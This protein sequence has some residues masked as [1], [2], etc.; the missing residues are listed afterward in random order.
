MRK[1]VRFCANWYILEWAARDGPGAA[2]RGGSAAKPPA[3]AV[4]TLGPPCP[5]VSVGSGPGERRQT[6]SCVRSPMWATAPIFQLP[7][8]RRGG[9]YAP[10]G[11]HSGISMHW[12]AQNRALERLGTLHG[13]ADAADC[14]VSVPGVL[15][16]GPS[17]SR[18]SDDV[19]VTSLARR[20]SSSVIRSAW[21]HCG[22]IPHVPAPAR[23]L[24]D[25]RTGMRAACNKSS[26]SST[27]YP[28]LSL[29]CPMHAWADP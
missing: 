9:R 27:W 25:A 29:A 18:P 5:A 21:S 28:F 14:S 16:A 11:R 26:C 12:C 22:S 7:P 24:R 2:V 17:C 20:T 19:S 8:S 3:P 15:C 4:D 6:R 1:L 23:L 10:G 13:A